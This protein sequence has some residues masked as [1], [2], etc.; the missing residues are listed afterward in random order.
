MANCLNCS[1]WK[2]NKANYCWH[3]GNRFGQS[4]SKNSFESELPVQIKSQSVIGQQV[5]YHAMILAFS[6]AGALWLNIPPGLSFAPPLFLLL[7]RPILETYWN[8]PKREPEPDK[9]TLKV[10]YKSEDKRH[11]MVDTYP[12]QIGFR[13]L[14]HI[15]KICIMNRETFSRRS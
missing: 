4:V 9:T 15:A 11:W 1:K 5:A 7:A 8:A 10:E 14:Q 2:V 13:H 3:C 6:Y 12:E